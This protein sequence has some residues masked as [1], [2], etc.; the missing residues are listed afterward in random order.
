LACEFFNLGVAEVQTSVEN[1]SVVVKADPSVS[2]QMMLEKLQKV[3][4]NLICHVIWNQT[5]PHLDTQ[6]IL[7]W[8]LFSGPK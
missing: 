4:T 1:K 5:E 8:G 6:Q 7:I 3:N 2:K